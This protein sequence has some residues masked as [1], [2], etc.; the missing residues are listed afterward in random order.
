MAKIALAAASVGLAAAAPF[1]GGASLY[2]SAISMGLAVGAALIPVHKPGIAPLQDLNVSS[3]A[4][5]APIPFGYGSGRFAGQ[6][7]WSPGI[8]YSISHTSSGGGLGKGGASQAG[9]TYF[10]YFATAFGEGPATISR[11]WA[12]SKLIYK[13]GQPFGSFAPW[14]PSTAYLPDDLTTYQWNPGTGAITELF[15]CVVPN[16]GIPPAGNSLYWQVASYPW[17]DSTVQYEP[18]NEVAYPG[19]LSEVAQS[20]AVYACTT[21]SLNDQPDT[22]PA[23][24]S[25]LETYYVAPTLYPG[26]ELQLPDPTIQGYEGADSTPAFRGICYGVWE[27]LPLANFGNRVPNLRAEVT[28]S[29]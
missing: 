17:W 20:G 16:T 19:L 18:G 23:H 21:P 2:L 1:T 29:L 4:N 8:V 6:V 11:V 15:L 24:W 3:A 9:Y 10:A 12:D 27:S 5:G 14:S 22:S 25:G 28:F 26:D 7:I 13:G